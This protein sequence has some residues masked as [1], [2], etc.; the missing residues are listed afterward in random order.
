MDGVKRLLQ[1]VEYRLAVTDAELDAHQRLRYEANLREGAILPND[2][3][4]LS[5]QFDTYEALPGLHVNG[6]DYLLRS[7]L[8]R[9]ENSLSSQDFE[10]PVLIISWPL[11]EVCRIIDYGK[12]LEQLGHDLRCQSQ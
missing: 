1:K 6:H 5:D 8:S 3:K 7:T 9:K 11:G 10:Y 12:N 2:E 4:R